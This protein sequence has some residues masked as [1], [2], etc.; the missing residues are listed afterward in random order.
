M[1]LWTEPV[2]DYN[3]Q[4]LVDGQLPKYRHAQSHHYL[5]LHFLKEEK[6]AA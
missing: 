4:H 2:C 5:Y 3:G 6:I 1:R